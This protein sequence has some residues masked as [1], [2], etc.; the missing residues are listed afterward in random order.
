MKETKYGLC[1]LGLYDY[2]GVEEHLSAMAAQGWRLEKAGNTLWKYRRAEPARLRYAVTYS[3]SASRFNPGPTEGQRSLEELCAAAGWEK[4]ADWDQAQIYSTADPAA[5]PLE[6][7]EALRLEGIHRS[8]KKNFL[9]ANAVL[10]V[11]VLFVARDFF[12][13]LFTGD[14]YG[15]VESNARL[16]AAAMS[17]STVCFEAYILA[18]YFLW[19]R[20]SQRSVEDGG[21]CVPVGRGY[22]RASLAMWILLALL[23]AAYLLAEL[24]GGGGGAALYF[25]SYTALFLLLGFLVRQT[26]ALMRKRKASKTANIAVTLAVD[27]VLAFALVGGLTY[28]ALHY[29]WFTGGFGS[30]E[31]YEYRGREWDVNPRQD[32]PLTLAELTGERY[33][34]VCRRAYN[35]GSFFVAERSYSES[36]LLQ[37]GPKFCGLD[38][39]VY[40]PRFS[41]IQ[42]SLLEDFL[43]DDPV[44]LPGIGT[45]FTSRYL[46]EDPA[47]WGAEAVYRHYYGE[48]PSGG[49]LL[50][51]PG[52]VVEFNPHG[53]LTEV[54]RAAAAARLGP[55]A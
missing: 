48:T 45:I 25:V 12:L 2:R 6:T 53:P 28:T 27:V 47:P 37:D 20:R 52:R 11:L 1:S 17:V 14:L 34:H 30:Q 19:R 3:D 55:E 38:Y 33:D 51:W 21:A 43:E 5:V 22:R 13:A 32:L 16:F 26:T 23:T 15:M 49:W 18:G 36:A 9:P 4:A 39:T 40:E 50:V 35:S 8:M 24:A 7:D 44:D 46:P 31:S 42:E 29:S 41:A 10:L 54:Q